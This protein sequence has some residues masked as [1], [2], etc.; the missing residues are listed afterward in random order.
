MEAERSGNEGESEAQLTAKLVE[1]LTK[2]EGSRES[3]STA[4]AWRLCVGRNPMASAGGGLE[5]SRGA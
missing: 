4:R 1:G 3:G 5:T 2:P